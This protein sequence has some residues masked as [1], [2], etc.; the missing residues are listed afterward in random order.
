MHITVSFTLTLDMQPRQ[1]RGRHRQLCKPVM[2]LHCRLS[3]S[4]ARNSNNRHRQSRCGHTGN[5][6]AGTYPNSQDTTEQAL[7]SACGNVKILKGF[8]D[9]VAHSRG[10]RWT[11]FF[12]SEL[13]LFRAS[14]IC[15]RNSSSHDITHAYAIHEWLN[16]HHLTPFCQKPVPSGTTFPPPSPPLRT[17]HPSRLH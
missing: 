15:Q 4:Q 11:N 2:H 13:R 17:C 1:C 8:T 7:S 9:I 10:K 6:C 14:I 5:H 3:K 16:H 12:S